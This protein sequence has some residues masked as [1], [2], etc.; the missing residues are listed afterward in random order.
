MAKGTGRIREGNV[1]WV[2][3]WFLLGDSFL[4]FFFVAP[5]PIGSC[6]LV[7]GH[8]LEPLQR[9]LGSWFVVGDVLAFLG[10]RKDHVLR[11]VTTVPVITPLL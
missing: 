2:S 6:Q 4:M 7:P 8:S 5:T 11:Q 9:A 1:N 3:F 10:E